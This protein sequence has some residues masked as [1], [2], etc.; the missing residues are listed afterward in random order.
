MDEY[1]NLLK[2]KFNVE[3]LMLEKNVLSNKSFN[4]KKATFSL[5]IKNNIKQLHKRNNWYNFLAIGYDWAIIF[6]AIY[7]AK[8]YPSWW[9]Y[10]I[11]IIVI[12]SRMRAFDNLMHEASHK[13][14][15]K[16]NKL[17]KWMACLFAAYPVL[18]SYTTYCN[19]HYSHH[20]HLWDINHDPDTKRY[21]LIGLDKPQNSIKKFIFKH[22]LKPL[23][24]MHVP[25]YIL[26]TISVNIFSKEEPIAEKIVK[27]FYWL[28]IILGS[29]Y[30][31]F[32]EELILFWVIPLL[33][34]FQII[35]YWA[36]MAEHSGLKNENELYASRNSFGNPLE[37]FLLHPHHD[38]Y[39]LVHHL[40]P[41]IPHYNLKKAHLIL[42][43]DQ[44]Y[45][46]AHHC[47]G[48]FKSFV[49]GLYSVIEDICGKYIKNKI[50]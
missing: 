47:T 48:F 40:F 29:V 6:L 30:F 2:A 4:M 20:R 14:L 25:K 27:L 15:F 35:R 31:N 28:L 8:E 43:H 13:L 5:E 32:W 17:N 36:E 22:I 42:M 26:G 46:K 38:N 11:S 16:N 18:T 34:T 49:P 7:I 1:V 23:T 45:K 41:A 37:I 33:T 3:V 21:A 44:E 24:L 10:L 39:H 50:N 9:V 12:G 19:S